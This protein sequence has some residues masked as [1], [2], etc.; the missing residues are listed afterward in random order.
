MLFILCYSLLYNV[1]V[2]EYL[3]LSGTVFVHYITIS[4]AVMFTIMRGFI[5]VNCLAALCIVHL[6][7]FKLFIVNSV[8]GECAVSWSSAHN[9][10]VR[11][12]CRIPL[13]L[14]NRKE[15]TNIVFLLFC[16]LKNFSWTS[17]H[18]FMKKVDRF[19]YVGLNLD[20]YKS[21]RKAGLIHII[22]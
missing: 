3:D 20:W 12:H 4:L 22:S 16:K 13:P 18:H 21:L 7:C 15:R 2:P 8:L 1:Q 10:C 19:L 11:V 9:F 14:W 5:Y 6:N 17:K